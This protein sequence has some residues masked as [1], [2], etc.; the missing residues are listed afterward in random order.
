MNDKPIVTKPNTV[1]VNGSYRNLLNN[2]VYQARSC[3]NGSVIIDQYF[4]VTLE[5][6]SKVFDVE[7]IHLT[8][9]E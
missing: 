1:I 4:I 6:F 3:S 5:E 9:N 2:N 7:P 8:L